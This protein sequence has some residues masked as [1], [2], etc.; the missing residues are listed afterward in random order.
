MDSSREELNGTFFERCKGYPLPS[1]AFTYTHRVKLSLPLVAVGRYPVV[2]SWVGFCEGHWAT[3]LCLR[4]LFGIHRPSG[5]TGALEWVGLR[6]CSL[7]PQ[8]L[9]VG[10]GIAQDLIKKPME[11]PREGRR[12]GR[13]ISAKRG[14]G[15]CVMQ[16]RNKGPLRPCVGSGPQG[17]HGMSSP[18]HVA[19]WLPPAWAPFPLPTA[20]CGAAVGAL[21]SPGRGGSM[22]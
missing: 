10:V 9:G 8:L 4:H 20:I 1:L 14:Y 17:G 18:F 22:I 3:N 2:L 16:P 6:A 19:L 13:A 12:G 21:P 7:G 11:A 5:G 15:S